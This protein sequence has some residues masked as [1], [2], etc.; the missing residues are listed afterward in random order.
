MLGVHMG[1][2]NGK[3][4]WFSAIRGALSARP[5]RHAG[6]GYCLTTTILCCIMSRKV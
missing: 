5:R 3:Q 2:I 1:A 4:G 6:P